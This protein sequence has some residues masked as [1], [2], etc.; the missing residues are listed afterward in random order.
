MALVIGR[1]PSRRRPPHS[2]PLSGLILV[3]LPNSTQSCSISGHT[4]AAAHQSP[5][6][7]CEQPRAALTH[8]IRPPLLEILEP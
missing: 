3:R 5:A 1:P 8:F 4:V 6:E 7:Q 2:S